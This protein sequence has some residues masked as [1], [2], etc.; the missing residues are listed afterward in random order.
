VQRL[1]SPGA[2]PSA[3]PAALSSPSER[4]LSTCVDR[5]ERSRPLRRWRQCGRVVWGSRGGSRDATNPR[6][7]SLLSMRV[8]E[9]KPRGAVSIHALKPKLR[10]AAGVRQAMARS[11][12]ARS[13]IVY[14]VISENAPFRAPKQLNTN[15]SNHPTDTQETSPPP[16]IHTSRLPSRKESALPAP[17]SKAIADGTRSGA[18]TTAKP[19]RAYHADFGSR[20]SRYTSLKA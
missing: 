2:A 19:C 12:T 18:S 17:I 14:M 7:G 9:S 5:G 15:Q 4:V 1:S 13:A 8:A 20:V 10:P 3:T 16:R 11:S 6:H